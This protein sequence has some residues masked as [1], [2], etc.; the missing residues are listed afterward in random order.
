MKTDLLCTC[1]LTALVL[2]ACG[3]GGGGGDDVGDDVAD[4]PDAD[5]SAPLVDRSGCHMLP[6]KVV[7]DDLACLATNFA[8]LVGNEAGSVCAFTDVVRWEWEAGAYYTVKAWDWTI[9][10]S[11]HGEVTQETNADS[12]ILDVPTGVSVLAVMTRDV[13]GKTYEVTFTMADDGV[14]FHSVIERL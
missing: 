4:P 1:A 2:A 12:G 10:S 9:E 6:A 5:E 11:T 7:S 8:C 13:D 14:V 3:G